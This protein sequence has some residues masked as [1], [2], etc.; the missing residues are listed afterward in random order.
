MKGDTI[1]PFIFLYVLKRIFVESGK[2]GLAGLSDG[3]SSSSGDSAWLSSGL[4]A[5]SGDSA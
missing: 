2:F 4:H 1:F 3:L 5:S